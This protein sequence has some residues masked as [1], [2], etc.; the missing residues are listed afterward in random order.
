MKKQLS[1]NQTY[2]S[3]A[4]GYCHYDKHPG[5]LNREL[6]YKHKC[7]AK[8]CR[9]LEKYSNEAWERKNTGIKR[10]SKKGC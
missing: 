9:H 4:I 5:A 1:I 2:I 8:K 10:D 3:N 7:I 6:A